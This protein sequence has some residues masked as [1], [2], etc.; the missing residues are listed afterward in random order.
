MRHL[1]SAALALAS[2]T[3]LATTMTLGPLP[4]AVA[5]SATTQQAAKSVS[6]DYALRAA[7]FGTRLYGGQVPAG[8]HQ[9]AFTA[10]GCGT[11]A[12]IEHENHEAEADLQGN[13]TVSGVK[14]KLWTTKVGDTVNTYS[15][16]TTAD[17]VL[18]QSGLGSI[19]ITAIKSLSHAW[20]DNQ[21]F[22][23]ETKTSVGTIE[24]VPPA[25]DPQ[26]FDV[27][28]PDQPI[29]IPG[30]ATIEVGSSVERHNDHAG[31]A[32]ADALRITLIPSATK[33]RVAHS[34]A[35]VLDGVKHGT[36]HG[37]SAGTKVS[38]ADGSIT[39]GRTP[40][41]LMPCQGTDGNLRTKAIADANLGDQII[42]QDLRSQQK[43][44]QFP[45]KSVALERG[46]IAE[47]N[48]GD[49][50]LI[51]SG[52]VGQANVERTAKGKLTANAKGTTIGAIT[53]NGEPQS[54]P[55]T[56]V[57]EIPGVAKL[58]PRIVDHTRSGISV[59]ALRITL[60]D[61][62]GAVIDLGV[63][64]ALIRRHR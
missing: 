46:T 41:S 39:S 32:A 60:L 24:F 15:R 51:V 20:H 3:A 11:K 2:A 38:A 14:T 10:M 64:K 43:A 35:Q 44:T 63:A 28:T 21:G 23:A 62:T 26:E 27:P 8:S 31:I 16:N 37:Y 5:Q 36:F 1:P 61:G 34:S 47:L 45:G 50:Q 7:G 18:A 53:A 49:G 55:D 25:G 56:G 4:G 9:T 17:L 48:L 40:L 54:F 59:V 22:H 6:V 29:D 33:L 57:L 13:G 52:V 58:E 30:F 19:H 12:G 42:V